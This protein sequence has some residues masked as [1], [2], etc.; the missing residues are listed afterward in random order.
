MYVMVALKSGNEIPIDIFIAILTMWNDLEH[1]VDHCH[2]LVE[3][4]KMK[5]HM[6][7]DNICAY[8]LK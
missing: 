8:F 3:W 7:F 2:K 1:G 4:G 5:W 6:V